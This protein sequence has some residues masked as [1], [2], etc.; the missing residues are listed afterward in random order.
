VRLTELEPQFLRL[1]RPGE[2]TS[3]GQPFSWKQVDTL[4]EAQG[5]RF[6]CPVCFVAN[7]GPVGTH[8]VVCWSRARGVPDSETPNPGRWTLLDGTGYDDLTLNGDPPG[9]ARSV[10]LTGGCNAHFHVTSGEVTS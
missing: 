9:N 2:L 1:A 3:D 8:Q 5:I 7:K 10:Q 6:L 4:A